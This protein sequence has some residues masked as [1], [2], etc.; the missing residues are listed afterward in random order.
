M[1][2]SARCL[3]SCFGL[4]SLHVWEQPVRRQVWNKTCTIKNENPLLCESITTTRGVFAQIGC[5]AR[6]G[7][8]GWQ[9]QT[10]T[11]GTRT[12]P[13]SDG[14]S[15]AGE[16]RF[17]KSSRT[18]D[19]LL[20]RRQQCF[21]SQQI[22]KRSQPADLPPTYRRDYRNMAKR[23]PSVDVAEMNLDSRNAHRSNGVP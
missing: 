4:P 17:V 16:P 12:G 11:V 19:E 22:A 14:K 18:L 5:C 8:I 15:L 10:G 23:L 7:F 9:T 2:L 21:E 1:S 13:R 6:L 20:V 3:S